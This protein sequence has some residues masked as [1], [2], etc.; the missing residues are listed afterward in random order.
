MAT[1]RQIEANRENSKKSSGPRTEGGRAIVGS[2]ALKH[3]ILSSRTLLPDEDPLEF[4]VFAGRIGVALQPDG[5]MERMFVDRVISTAWR[6]RRTVEV[7]A[8][9][10]SEQSEFAIGVENVAALFCQHQH[11]FPVL[12]RYEAGLERSLFKA[13]HELQR[14]QAFRRGITTALPVAVDI[15]LAS[16]LRCGE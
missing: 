8:L 6:L 9:L 3:G 10:F 5:E 2:N 15:D 14:L 11:V 7:D 13:L 12:S 1:Q 16:D 4:E